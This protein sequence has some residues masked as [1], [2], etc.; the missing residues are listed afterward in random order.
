MKE[1]KP[2]V[3]YETDTAGSHAAACLAMATVE[4]GA[5]VQTAGWGRGGD[6]ELAKL[7]ALAEAVERHAYQQPVAMHAARWKDLAN[8]LHPETL[9]RYALEQYASRSIS[10]RAFDPD[11]VYWWIDGRAWL[12]DDPVSILADCVLSPAVFDTDYRSRMYTTAS[13]SGCASG[14]SRDDAVL[15]G[16]L[17]LLE[18]DAFMRHWLGSQAASAIAQE[19]LPATIQQRLAG[20]R[21]HG[22]ELG[23]RCLRGSVYPSWL[24]W[25]QHEVLHF[26]SVG[27]CSGLDAEEALAGA[28]DELEA[29]VLQNLLGV[30]DGVA[31]QAAQVV[32]PED[33][34]A[35]YATQS[36]FRKADEWLKP[37]DTT[38][39]WEA[40]QALFASSESS[41]LGVLQRAGLT[42]YWTDLSLAQASEIAD[43]HPI[44]TV[45]TFIPGLIPLTFGYG[46]LPLGMHIHTDVITNPIH[47]LA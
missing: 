13:S 10:F 25:A 41:L 40:A 9:V 31:L 3:S 24:V 17:E 30:H 5:G 12:T 33:H 38:L 15:R 23:I 7:K 4:W 45:R 6:L 32:T 2:F 22:A 28:L 43:G 46:R 29:G 44:Y 18:R 37:V 8:V 20:L 11:A 19:T 39:S 34:G 1:G 21:Q 26:T 42:L 16:A 27:S 36:Y 14:L 47:P 35:L